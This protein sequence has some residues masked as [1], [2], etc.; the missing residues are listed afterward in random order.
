MIM[1]LNIKINRS[2]EIKNCYISVFWTILL[3]MV[4]SC[5]VSKRH[6]L[7]ILYWDLLFALV[8]DCCHAKSDNFFHIYIVRNHVETLL[9][10]I[11][12]ST[13]ISTFATCI[14]TCS[15]IV[16]HFETISLYM[17]RFVTVEANRLFSYIS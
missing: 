13:T 9:I 10:T 7:S 8:N 12:V 4:V 11:N 14:S 2:I 17:A 6:T 5:H 3:V 16:S 15:K 1:S